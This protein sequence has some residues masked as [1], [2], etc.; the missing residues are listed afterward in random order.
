[1]S[2]SQAEKGDNNHLCDKTLAC[3]TEVVGARN[4][5]S[6][7]SPGQ[8]GSR[9]QDRACGMHGCLNLGGVPGV[10]CLTCHVGCSLWRTHRKPRAPVGQAGH[11]SR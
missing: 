9:R 10:G 5:T 7:S 8:P 4:P 2:C 1:M 3:S 11:Q 6:R